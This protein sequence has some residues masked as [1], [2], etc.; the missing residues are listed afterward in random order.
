MDR[1]EY[2]HQD[3]EDLDPGYVLSK[4]DISFRDSGIL[5]GL[6]MCYSCRWHSGHGPSPKKLSMELI[7]VGT[8]VEY[9]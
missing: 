5:F 9:Y 2:V 4:R 7:T 6:Q 3:E 1:Y 8:F